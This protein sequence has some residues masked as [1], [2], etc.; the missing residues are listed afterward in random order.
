MRMAFGVFALFLMCFSLTEAD[1][2]SF[3]KK[4][5]DAVKDVVQAAPSVIAPVPVIAVKVIQGKKPDEA[6]KEVAKDN[7]E[8]LIVPAE[9]QLQTEQAITDAV[10]NKVGKLAPGV[11]VLQLPDKIVKESF[12]ETGKMAEHII[13]TG[14]PGE[15]VGAPAAAAI[16]QAYA[17]YESVAKPIPDK[18]RFWLSH[19]YTSDVLDNARYTVDKGFGSI[20]A[21]LAKYA[22]DKDFGNI[23][24]IFNG[25]SERSGENFAVTLDN[26]IVFST[27]PNPDDVWWW[28][29]EMQHTVQY[30]LLGIEGFAARY[31]L[32]WKDMEAEAD[33]MGDKALAEANKVIR[34]SAT[35]RQ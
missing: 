15:L 16:R 9:A 20:E 30:K 22:L 11:D 24:A 4:V 32:R 3:F 5:K 17:N 10:K 35:Q 6:V 25:M 34:F 18:V 7:V 27:E 28:G 31:T 14:K 26:I 13:D 23:A 33:G 19:V 12:V 21:I 29:H 1:A 2:K 8:I